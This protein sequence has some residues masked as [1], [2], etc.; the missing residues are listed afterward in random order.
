[1]PKKLPLEVEQLLGGFA[2]MSVEHSLTMYEQT[3]NPVYVWD[4][5]AVCLRRGLDLPEPVRDYLQRVSK[6]ISHLSRRTIPRAGDITATLA[7]A[8]EFREGGRTGADN[9]FTE[10]TDIAHEQGIAFEV[11]R[12][13]NSAPTEDRIIGAVGG[14]TK[15]DSAFRRVAETHPL[16]CEHPKKCSTISPSTVRAYWKKHAA[17]YPTPHGLLEK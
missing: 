10:I 1:M 15:E 6:E 3:R 4:V 17:R 7:S 5:I 16:T 8:L 11:F 14:H 12:Q 9:P 2:P 13:L